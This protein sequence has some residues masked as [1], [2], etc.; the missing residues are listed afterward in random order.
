[1]WPTDS[2]LAIVH[3]MARCHTGDNP[4]PEPMMTYLTDTYIYL[5]A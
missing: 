3:V 1:M 5:C 2:K 4:L